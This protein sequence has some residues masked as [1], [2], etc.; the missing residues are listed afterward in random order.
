MI[1]VKNIIG[2]ILF[3]LLTLPVGCEKSPLEPSDTEKKSSTVMVRIGDEMGNRLTGY[4]LSITPD[5]NFMRDYSEINQG[6]ATINTIPPG[7]YRI[8]VNC[9][10]DSLIFIEDITVTDQQLYS[11]I[12]TVPSKFSVKVHAISQN[13]NPVDEAL[14]LLKPLV[15]TLS[16]TAEAI[17]DATGTVSFD[18]I[19]F[20]NENRVLE[21]YSVHHLNLWYPILK[22]VPLTIINGQVQ[23]IE[24][25]VFDTSEVDTSKNSSIAVSIEDA[26]GNLHGSNK[27]GRL[28]YEGISDPIEVFTI[29]IGSA[30]LDSIPPGQ[31]YI[32]FEDYFDHYSSTPLILRNDVTLTGNQTVES[33]FV[34]PAAVTLHITVAKQNENRFLDDTLLSTEPETITVT[35]DTDGHAVF[36]NIPIT[37]YAF[38]LTP[39]TSIVSIQNG[40]YPHHS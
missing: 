10:H 18:N 28:Y 31:Y 13:G 25:T 27:R 19:P 24:I 34:I 2:I 40:Y 38:N 11:L 20:L 6:I 26:N 9:Y 17:T 3:I 35:T 30:V 32:E 15:T 8:T 14:I 39:F 36:E 33:K 16:T 12:F 1:I 21:V 23:D 5:N 7:D 22:T 37:E 29:E 4:S